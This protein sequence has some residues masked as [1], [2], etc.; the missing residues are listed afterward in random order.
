MEL[1]LKEKLKLGGETSGHI[2]NLD[3]TIAGDGIIAALQVL[4]SMSVTGKK[5]SDLTA[6]ITKYPQLIRNVELER[7]TDISKNAV[8]NDAIKDAE[9]VLGNSGRVV[10]RVSGTEPFIRVMVEAD[11]EHRVKQLIDQLAD[12]VDEALNETG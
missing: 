1:L 7:Q 3:Y 11:D 2:I 6:G 5:L 12:R 8:I 9:N 10:L 4:E